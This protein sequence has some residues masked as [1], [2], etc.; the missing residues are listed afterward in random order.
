MKT[1]VDTSASNGLLCKKLELTHSNGIL[2][3]KG[4]RSVNNIASK[5]RIPAKYTDKK[6]G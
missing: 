5:Q 1:T 6:Q 3:K 4:I 2:L